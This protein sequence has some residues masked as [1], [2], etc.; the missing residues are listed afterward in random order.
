MNTPK[1]DVVV[2]I[3]VNADRQILIAKRPNGRHLSGFW[4]FP[5]GKLEA[6]ETLEDALTRELQ[7]EIGV[8]VE[9]CKFLTLVEH[10]YPE[11]TVFLSVYIVSEFQGIPE[12]L[13][14]QDIRWVTLEE[15]DDYIFPPANQPI[16]ESL[17]NVL[18]TQHVSFL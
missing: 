8:I 6:G 16:I 4:E 18:S 5:G 15:L 1:V 10:H 17:K 11:K 12:S 2:G 7:E 9:A 3:L 14:R 13:E